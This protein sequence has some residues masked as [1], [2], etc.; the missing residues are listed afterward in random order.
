MKPYTPVCGSSAMRGFSLIELMTALTI[1]MLLLMGL[2]SVF[3]NTS[4]SYRELKKTSEQIENGRYAI[5][6]LSQDVRH[7]GFYGEFA[8]L[9]A[10][11]ASLPDPCSAPS[12]ALVTD[13]VNNFLALPVQVYPAGSLTTRPSVP[14]ACAALLPNANLM[15]GSDIVV[16]RRAD[17]N[18]V[19]GTVTG[20]VYYLQATS[21]TADLQLGSAGA[22]TNLQNARRQAS[23][24]VRRDLSVA[25]TGV[26]AQFPQIAAA[27]RLYR[28]HIYFVAPCSVPAGGVVSSVCT[29]N[30]DDQGK[31]IPTLK[32]LEL[33]A[34][35][36]FS[37]VPLTE[38]IEALR[39]EAG[40]DTAP[41]VVDPG[42]GFIGDGNPD[43]YSHST[44]LTATDMTNLVAARI[45]V[46]ARNTETTTGY[47]DDKAYTMGTV[48]TA[49]TGDAYRRHVYG[50]ET[51]IAN[52]A[53]RRE[54][55]R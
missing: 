29:G 53:G 31:P 6:L 18:A 45:Y 2:A 16:V 35:G 49:A 54:I 14:T 36:L 52:Q 39:F 40:L 1:G 55:P 41:G 15:P 42:T 46:L 12:D 51:R 44:T 26:P 34:G 48:T 30:A 33:G 25:A 13:T 38:G 5:E 7:A 19:S 21:S 23:T 43:S 24:L 32:R 4:Q 28:T 50:T 47:V 27:I 37:I 22:I 9:P 8:K 17:T 3:V 11:P 10:A 20:N